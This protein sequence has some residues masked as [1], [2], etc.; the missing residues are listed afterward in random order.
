[1]DQF[2]PQLPSSSTHRLALFFAKC[3]GLHF[4]DLIDDL[5]EFNGLLIHR[6][7]MVLRLLSIVHVIR[8]IW[9]AV[10]RNVPKKHEHC[11]K[12]HDHCLTTQA[13]LSLVQKYR[14]GKGILYGVGG[15]RIVGG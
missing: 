4:K 10:K 11:K 14:D 15:L 2:P 8:G 1:M 5:W 3:D 12:E 7:H 13:S 9:Y 6:N